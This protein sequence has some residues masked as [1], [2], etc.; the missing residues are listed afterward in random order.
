LRR[1]ALGLSAAALAFSLFQLLVHT[2]IDLVFGAVLGLL[3]GWWGLCI[4][5]AGRAEPSGFAGLVVF[6]LGWAFAVNGV[7]ELVASPPEFEGWDTDEY[8]AIGNAVL[9][10]LAGISSWP[11]ARG[12][13]RS[14]DFLFPVAL[15]AAA[16]AAKAAS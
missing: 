8:A 3:Y 13:A 12:R 6:A 7:A 4:T 1:R 10:A 5:L 11:E 14:R 9:G 15:T 2:S 16:L